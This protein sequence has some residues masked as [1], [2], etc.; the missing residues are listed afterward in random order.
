MAQLR[1]ITA[2]LHESLLAKISGLEDGMTKAKEATSDE[3]VHLVDENARLQEELQN[4]TQ[5]VSL[6]RMCKL[7]P[8]SMHR[9]KATPLCK[10]LSRELPP[11]QRASTSHG[12]NSSPRSR[13]GVKH[14]MNELRPWREIWSK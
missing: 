1:H 3:R 9:R 5:R 2:S 10:Y 6:K 13:N 11:R 14:P 8:S 12:G 4:L 7:M